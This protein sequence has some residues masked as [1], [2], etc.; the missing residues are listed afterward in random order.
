MCLAGARPFLRGLSRDVKSIKNRSCAL[1]DRR[2]D[3][4][5]VCRLIVTVLMVSSALARSI[6]FSRWIS[7]FRDHSTRVNNPE[8]STTA[9]RWRRPRDSCR[10]RYEDMAIR[11][12]WSVSINLGCDAHAARSRILQ[13]ECLSMMSFLSPPPN[14][15]PE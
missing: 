13:A 1:K 6:G 9:K 4:A 12:T 15:Y 8:K 14:Q 2:N 11:P 3:R 10:L 5:T 7:R